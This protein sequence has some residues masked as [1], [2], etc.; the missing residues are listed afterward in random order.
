M[1]K[2]NEHY[3]INNLINLSYFRQLFLIKLQKQMLKINEHFIKKKQQNSVHG[4]WSC[5]VLFW[6]FLYSIYVDGLF[7]THIRATSIACPSNYHKKDFLKNIKLEVIK[8][9]SFCSI[10]LLFFFF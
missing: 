7:V 8:G 5:I 6:V 2:H 1:F 3:Y 4:Q 10:I 9:P